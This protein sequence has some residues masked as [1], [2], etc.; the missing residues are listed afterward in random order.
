MYLTDVEYQ[1]FKMLFHCTA[2][3]DDEN[4][5]PL[6]VQTPNGNAAWTA[7]IAGSQFHAACDWI[8]QRRTSPA[9]PTT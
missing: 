6:S 7:Y 5:V 1:T 9:A 3:S 2:C 4:R 8:Q